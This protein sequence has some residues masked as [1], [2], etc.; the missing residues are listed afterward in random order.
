MY[1]L[2]RVLPCRATYYYLT[3]TKEDSFENFVQTNFP[4][5]IVQRD[6]MI[7]PL[8]LQYLKS[9]SISNRVLSLSVDKMI[10]DLEMRKKGN[11]SPMTIVE[12][13][14]ELVI[15]EVKKPKNLIAIDNLVFYLASSPN[16]GKA[17]TKVLLKDTMTLTPS[18]LN[19]GLFRF[20]D[21]DD[22]HENFFVRAF[23]WY[24]FINLT[25]EKEEMS[26]GIS[27]GNTNTFD[28]IAN[29]LMK[30]YEERGRKGWE[31]KVKLIK[32]NTNL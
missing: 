10:A 17:I 29:H 25:V 19:K 16:I 28:L 3:G 27:L 6:K 22:T 31:G 9:I 32:G 8:F 1:S 2:F 4:D 24:K 13:K 23:E 12:E 11:W 26:I 7:T 20:K 15:K 5:F 21:L 14:G 30:D 18:S